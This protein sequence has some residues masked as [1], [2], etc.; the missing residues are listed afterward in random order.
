MR[1]GTYALRDVLAPAD[2]H[3]LGSLTFDIDG[4]HG[5]VTFSSQF[6]PGNKTCF[7][8]DRLGSKSHQGS[9]PVEQ[10]CS[11]FPLKHIMT[12][13]CYHILF[14]KQFIPLHNIQRRQASSGSWPPSVEPGPGSDSSPLALALVPEAGT[15]HAWSSTAPTITPS[16]A[17]GWWSRCSG[18]YAENLQKPRLS[19]SSGVR[20][21]PGTQL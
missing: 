1:S 17:S 15:P 18:F 11:L 14:H 13:T 21:F 4:L 5:T 3:P 12:P 16:F 10:F 19:G 7:K 6:D 2:P 8:L 9:Y 20:Y